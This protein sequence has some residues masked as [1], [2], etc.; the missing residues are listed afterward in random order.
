MPTPKTRVSMGL[1][2]PVLLC[3]SFLLLHRCSAAATAS[4][5]QASYCRKLCL[6]GLG[7]NLCQ[8]NAIHFAGK[9]SSQLPHEDGRWRSS[10]RDDNQSTPRGP[11]AKEESGNRHYSGQDYKLKRLESVSAAS[12]KTRGSAKATRRGNKEHTNTK[13]KLHRFNDVHVGPFPT[14]DWQRHAPSQ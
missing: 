2:L 11:T 9:R 14:G 13:P 7:G 3:C 6:R 12:K 8:C 4:F 1:F 10:A 5:E